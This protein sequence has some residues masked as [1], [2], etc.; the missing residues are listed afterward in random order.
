MSRQSFSL[1]GCMLIDY[2]ELFLKICIVEGGV[3]ASKIVR[4]IPSGEKSFYFLLIYFASLGIGT[5]V[6]FFFFVSLASK[7]SKVRD[8]FLNNHS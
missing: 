7:S 1:L 8:G 2:I 3:F 6:C 5:T 4:N